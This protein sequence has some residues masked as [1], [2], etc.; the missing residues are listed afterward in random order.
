MKKLIAITC[1][2]LVACGT[3]H[4]AYDYDETI[5]FSSYK[6]YNYYPNLK[7]GLNQ[8]D[9]KR[10][11]AATDSLLESKGFRKA[12]TPAMY[13]NFKS[14]TYETQSRNSVGIGIGSGPLVI[15]G[16]VPV[17]VPDQHIQLTMDFVDVK[18]DELIWQAEI[19]DVQN[20][21]NT[22]ENRKAFFEVMMDKALSKYPP[23][24]KK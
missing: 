24:K 8:L 10:L 16:S 20:S 11:L 3:A 12:N 17:G 5:D 9:T 21:K 13:V 23:S 14:R 18:K 22:P 1:L 4:V 19:D 6:T 7:S 2:C 15:G